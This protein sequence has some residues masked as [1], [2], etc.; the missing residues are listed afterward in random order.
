MSDCIFC[1]YED[2]EILAENKLVYAVLD[3]FPVNDGHCLI[4][5]KRHF[6]SFFDAKEEEVKAIYALMHEVK[7]I[8]DIQYEPAGY[9]IG[10]NVGT[11]AGQTVNHVHVHLIPRYVGDVED[12]RGG[13]RNLKEAMTDYEG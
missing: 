2:S 8:F 12:P 1:N 5:P 10:I 9:N 13:V 4:I 7:E 11:Y 3:H 6:Q